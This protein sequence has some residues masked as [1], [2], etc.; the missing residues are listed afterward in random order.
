VSTPNTNNSTLVPLP[1]S[2]VY[3]K[4]HDQSSWVCQSNGLHTTYISYGLACCTHARAL[5]P[6]PTDPVRAGALPWLCPTGTACP[7]EQRKVVPWETPSNMCAPELGRHPC[8]PSM[9]PLQQWVAALSSQAILLSLVDY[10]VDNPTSLH[11]RYGPPNLA[12]AR[13]AFCCPRM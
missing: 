6:P 10:P 7:C 11:L 12:T 9:S 3:K 1:W 5:A 8:Q 2:S 4:S 13:K